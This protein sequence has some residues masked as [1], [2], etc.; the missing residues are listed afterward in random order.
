MAAADR[1]NLEQIVGPLGF[2][3]AKTESLLKLSAALVERYD[4]EVP[5]PAR[6]PGHAARRRPQDR[7]R[8]ARQRVRHPRHHRR[9]PLRPARPP[10]SA[11]PRR[12]T[13][14]RSS[15]PIGALFPKRDWTMLSHHLIWHGR[16]RLPRPEARLRR[17]PGGAAGARRTAPGPTDPDDAAKLVQDRGPRMSRALRCRWLARAGRRC[18]SAATRCRPPGKTDVDV[19]TAELRA[20]Q[21]RGRHRGLRGRARRRRSSPTSRCP[22]SAAAPT[23][24][25]PRCAVRW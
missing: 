17:L 2:F 16:R 6:R 23:S 11:G 24:T 18:S 5:A 20:D 13:R 22:A 15:T 8:G 3:R 9:H 25:C 14:S 1:D 7:Q 10:A 4:G 19:D 21:G 12:P